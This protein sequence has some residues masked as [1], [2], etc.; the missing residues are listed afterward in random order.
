M[1][2]RSFICSLSVSFS[3]SHFHSTLLTVNCTPSV[4]THTIVMNSL[5]SFFA[6]LL[7]AL[8][9]VA[10]FAPST[11]TCA[12]TAKSTALQFGFL[13]ELGLEKPDWLPDFGGEK[14]EDAP[15]P[16]DAEAS[17]EDAAEAEPVAEE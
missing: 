17:E 6:I 9:A 8:T 13:K 15:A 7:V 10:A 14:K 5:R 4:A 11:P 2:L 1:K 16:V 3:F 12:G